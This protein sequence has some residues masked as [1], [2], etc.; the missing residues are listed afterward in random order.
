MRDIRFSAWWGGETFYDLELCFSK[1]FS[2]KVDILIK[3]NGEE[4]ADVS[5]AKVYWA[6]EDAS[7]MVWGWART[8][9]EMSDIEVIGYI[10]ENPELLLE[11]K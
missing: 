9:G 11:A 1:K 7:F 6:N 2:D 4:Y 10:H 5:H 3:R 8:L